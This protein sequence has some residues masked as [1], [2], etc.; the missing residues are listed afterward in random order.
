LKYLYSSQCIAM[1]RGP[2]I[3]LNLVHTVIQ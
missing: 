2:L 3:D 1:K